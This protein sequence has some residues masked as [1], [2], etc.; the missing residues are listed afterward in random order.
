M[1]QFVAQLASF[2]EQHGMWAGPLLGLIAF[3]ESLAIIGLFVP[4]TALMLMIG[5]LIGSGVIDPLPVFLWSV[6][7]SVL[8]DALSYAIGRGL[9]SRIYYRAPLNRHLPLVARTRLFFRRYGFWSVLIGRFL[10]P[11]RSTIPLVAGVMRMP[12]RP[13]QIANLLS[14]ILWVPAMLAPGFLAARSMGGIDGLNGTQWTFATLGIA[15]ICIIGP[16]AGARILTG[17]LERDPRRT[18]GRSIK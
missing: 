8:G 15:L 17:R 3:G 2:L 13:F 1:D 10:G 6:V 12:Q 7:G 18:M 14:A 4:A 5:G 11:I 9:G 16:L